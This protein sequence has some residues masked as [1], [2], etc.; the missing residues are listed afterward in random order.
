MPYRSDVVQ[1]LALCR[2]DGRMDR[3]T[4]HCPCRLPQKPHTL[5]LPVAAHPAKAKD[6]MPAVVG[7]ESFVLAAVP[8]RRAHGS[9][10]VAKLSEWVIYFEK[11]YA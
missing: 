8:P 5:S 11:V 9:F 1:G 2:H 4:S 3:H 7:I 6:P 10:G